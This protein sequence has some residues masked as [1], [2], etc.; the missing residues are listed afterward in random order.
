[1]TPEQ[2]KA[3]RAMAGLSQQSLADASKVAKATIAA[4]EQGKRK[5]YD[6]TLADLQDALEARGVKFTDDG[7]RTNV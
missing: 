1:M 7:V 3:A 5:P 2:C 6:R 4:F